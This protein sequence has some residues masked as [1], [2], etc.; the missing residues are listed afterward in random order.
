MT[1]L[2]KLAD[3]ELVRLYEDGNNDAFDVLLSR[4]QDKLFNYIFFLVRDEELANDL[5]QDTFVRAITSIRTHSYERQGTFYAWLIRISRNLVL[6]QNRRVMHN[7]MMPHEFVDASGEVK[8]DLLDKTSLCERT[9]EDDLFLQ[10]SLHLLRFMV[11]RLPESQREIIL[12]R[13]YDEL[14]FK[15][16]AAMLHI[17]INTA[18]GRV[19]YA[20]R[21]LRRMA[22]KNE[23]CMV[24]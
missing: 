16:I 7:V 1:I 14:S 6:D 19:H 11:D 23:L 5:F 20:I 4:H 22:A 17:S 9:I 2:N 12:L 10:E 8:V 21:N 18:L 3:D 15:E 24:G 13:Y